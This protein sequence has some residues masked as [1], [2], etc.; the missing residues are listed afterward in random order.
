MRALTILFILLFVGSCTYMQ[1]INDG[2][3]A[4]D[5][6]QFSLAIKMLPQEYQSE[7]SQLNKAKLAYMLAESFDR[8]LQNDQA[9]EWYK[10]AYDNGYGIE[11]LKGYATSLKKAE[12]YEE[13]KAAF[14]ELG[15]ELGSPY[16]FRKDISSCDIAMGWKKNENDNAYKIKAS[17][18]NSSSAEYGPYIYRDGSVIYTSDKGSTNEEE[19]Y[20]W[21]GN[22]FSDLYASESDN[23]ELNGL[24]ES[25][26]TPNNNEG[27]LSF[28]KSQ[29][30][31]IFTRCSGEDKADHFCKLYYS[32]LIEGDWS[33]A[34]VAEFTKVGVNYGHPTFHHA[35]KIV[36][37]SSNDPD[38][39][40]GY[41]IYASELGEEGWKEPRLLGRSINTESDEKFPFLDGDTLYFAS[42]GHTGM[43]GL[44]V[45]KTFLQ[46]EK[47]WTAVQNLLPPINSGH[48]DFGFIV[49]RIN[50]KG[51]EIIQQGYFCS[52]RPLG[53][54]NDDVYTFTKIN[55]PPKVV[56]EPPV[57]IKEK[58]KVKAIEHKIMLEV[59]VVEKI[60]QN[61]KD[62]N[63]KVLG[64][65]PISA[66]LLDMK[67]NNAKTQKVKANN[68]SSFTIE[69]KE[70]SDYYFFASKNNYLNKNGSF[71]TKGIAK[72]DKNPVQKFELEIV[73][74]KIYKDK[75]IVLENIYY[76]Y[77]KW[78]IR[79]DAEPTL[80]KLYLMLSQNP[81]IKIQLASH[82]DCRGKDAYNLSLSQKRAQSAVDYLIKKGIQTDRLTAI[83]YGENS[84]AVN[85]NC[86]DCDENQHQANRRTT[87]KVID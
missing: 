12:R 36:F 67:E 79:T 87:F 40:G 64:K 41:D 85:C 69:L 84:L 28:N 58:P 55:P 6:K 10:T 16:E 82:T 51:T 68:K 19:V 50:P 1:K 54:G 39:W 3:T 48:D 43:G 5:R 52:S 70:E 17:P 25:I 38:G 61:E 27:T 31:M 7:K 83:G 77:D 4:Y 59:F 37:F 14:K 8:T 9:I 62:P 22:R 30:L 46:N 80:S 75:E 60:L 45:F 35:G 65:R 47:K 78:L 66:A 81:T 74:D 42:D 86:D 13:A 56:E 2:S 15:I 73:L 21:T 44:D 18:F 49:D 34:R 53:E 33:E 24:L 76:D 11:S 72:D 20:K 71:S 29:D 32:E 63:S 57:V 26:N 23:E